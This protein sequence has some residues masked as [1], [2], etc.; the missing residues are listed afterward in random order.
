MKLYWKNQGLFEPIGEFDTEQEAL[1]KVSD[2]LDS[3]RIKT[4]YCR[5]LMCD[6]GIVVDYGSYCNFFYIV[7]D[8]YQLKDLIQKVGL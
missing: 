4:D 5:H 1:R 2:I 8:G 6:E 7:A 3:C